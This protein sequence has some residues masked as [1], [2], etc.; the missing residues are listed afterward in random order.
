MTRALSI[1]RAIWC[2]LFH[3]APMLPFKGAYECRT[4]QRK[5]RVAF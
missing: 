3:D 5:V 4:C 2:E 1:F